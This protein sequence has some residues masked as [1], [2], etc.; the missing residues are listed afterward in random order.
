MTVKTR[1]P[2]LQIMLAS[3]FVSVC[4]F[5]TVSSAYAVSPFWTHKI[6][7]A[8]R[9]ETAV[10]ISQSG[11]AS[12][13]SVIVTTGMN[14]PDALG[15]AGLSGE[16]DAPIL[17]VKKDSIPGVVW[18][19]INR[20]SPGIVYILGGEG[21]VGPAVEA[22]LA[23]KVGS[24]NVYRLAGDNRYETSNAVAK[25]SIDIQDITGPPFYSGWAFVATGDEFRTLSRQA[26]S[27]QPTAGP[28]SLR[29]LTQTPCPQRS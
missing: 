12:S 28:S 17:L 7:G 6:A 13:T 25:R 20:L 1:I 5:A 18:D 27:L 8:D 29:I 24:A 16:L 26:H 21:V 19:E 4:L 11:W 3:L 23:G 14:W 10:K 22:Q 2:L 15:G 9:F